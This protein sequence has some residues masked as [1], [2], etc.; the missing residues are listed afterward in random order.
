MPHQ[1][2]GF[3]FCDFCKLTLDS[4]EE[5]KQHEA[6]EC[7]QNPNKSQQQQ[8]L[9]HP[10]QP[11]HHQIHPVPPAAG[12][13]HPQQ[14]PP[15]PPRYHR[16]EIMAPVTTAPKQEARAYESN[17]KS[18]ALMGI[19][20]TSHMSPDDSVACQS[21]EIFEAG[22]VELSDVE[23]RAEFP[24]IAIGHLGLRCIHCSS[25]PKSVREATYF[26]SSIASN[27]SL[28]HGVRVLSERH[29]G[30]CSMA[31]A[32]VRD[33]NQQ[34][35]EKRRNN[36]QEQGSSW[37][38]DENSRS[39]LRDWCH[40]FCQRMGI[41]E[42]GPDQNGLVFMHRNA[43]EMQ[44]PGG[45]PGRHRP[46][47]M[48]QLGA[49]PLAPTPVGRRRNRP[50]THEGGEYRP[51]PGYG[52]YGHREMYY[53][54]PDSSALQ[55]P[56]SGHES[57]GS[58]SSPTRGY[59]QTVPQME[60]TSS[61]PYYQEANGSWSCKYCSH[62]PPPYR[63]P[64]AGWSVP[65]HMPPPPQFMD[66]HLSMCR[67]Y[68]QSMMAQP[69]YPGGPHHQFQFMTQQYPGG[70]GGEQQPP[71][72]AQGPG[73]Q[74]Y[75][76]PQEGQE[77]HSSGQRHMPAEAAY[78]H[79]PHQRQGPTS[80]R[81]AVSQSRTPLPATSSQ[82]TEAPDAAVQHAIDYLAASDREATFTP[83]GPGSEVDQLVLDEDKL[84]LTD[85]FFYLMKQLRLCRFSESDRKTRGGKREKIVIGFGGL[86]CIHCAE[87]NNS[88]KF[89]WSNVDR[90]ANSF[91]EIPGHVLKCRHC[92]Q[93]TIDAL[94]QLKQLHPEQMARLPRGSQKVFFRRMWRRL[95]DEDPQGANPEQ[96]TPPQPSVGS[97]SQ[98][99]DKLDKKP[100]AVATKQSGNDTSP[101]GASGSDE[102]FL[103]M[104]RSTKEAAKALA[105][106]VSVSMPP[107]PNS[108]VLLAIPEDKEWLSD[109]DC[110]VRRQIE[111]FCATAEDV[112][113]AKKDR[114]YPVK[115]GQVGIRCVHC[116]LAKGASG[117]GVA[118]PFSVSGIYESVREFQ[119]LHLDS[120][121]SLPRERKSKLA[122]L[123]GSTSLSS[124]L[125]KYYVLAAKALGLTDTKDGIRAGA[126]SVPIGSQAAFAFSEGGSSI[127]D[128]MRG[129][130]V[131]SFPELPSPSLTP[132]ESRKRKQEDQPEESPG[133]SKRPN[134]G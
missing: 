129:P 39:A 44:G 35:T 4:L 36:D 102:S 82:R 48:G 110:F 34:A 5:A 88:R 63:D 7:L 64:Q 2:R 59:Q 61:Y 130:V 27:N 33:I 58:S 72:E 79:T 23:L 99:S 3:W 112:E 11:Q 21:L 49:D 107:S 103:M 105:D 83:G 89:F 127:S 55:P 118:Y 17:R 24:S 95:H 128:E 20:E 123:K 133:S 85:Y 15:Y 42:K 131:A 30:K 91:A 22:Q 52:S 50:P 84:L 109:T 87:A 16:T 119:R 9:P 80:S 37:Q 100:P 60:I 62:I 81:G 19:N 86:Q 125:R 47:P 70:F 104:Q 74:P 108:R 40:R 94:Y 32:S 53:G 10:H 117:S 114:K 65:N 57:Q 116:S 106:S 93:P 68:H 14:I 122:D 29:L 12:Y 18:F 96:S 75:A 101:S 76:Y 8:H 126:D 134:S 1:A 113:A 54:A 66:Q 13:Y 121:E 98:S 26:P 46:G 90:L 115:G 45:F 31:P 120:C 77:R 73:S 43:E 124:V 111:V 97:G 132:V 38:E 6:E 71:W 78:P 92:P 25:S 56:P 41:V 67:A 51:M 28:S 69:M